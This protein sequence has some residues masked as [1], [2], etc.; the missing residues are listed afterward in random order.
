MSSKQSAFVQEMNRPFE[1]FWLK[2][3]WKLRLGCKK[4][5]RIHF[6]PLT[7][8]FRWTFWGYA[9]GETG[10]PALTKANIPAGQVDSHQF[11]SGPLFAGFTDR[12]LAYVY[13]GGK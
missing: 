7:A 10:D 3:G 6:R 8:S 12:V 11:N 1:R 5:Q 13:E 2:Q 4:L 9:I